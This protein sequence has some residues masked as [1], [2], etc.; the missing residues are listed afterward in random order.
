MAETTIANVKLLVPDTELADAA[1]TQFIDD[2]S[3]V[4]TDNLSGEGYDT[5]TQEMIERYL[6]AHFITVGPE[7]RAASEKAGPVGISYQYK[8]GDALKSTMFGQTAIAL[9]KSGKLAGLGDKAKNATITMLGGD[10]DN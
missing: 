10:G 8:L 1:I 7:P 2:A 9:D 5:T 4:F 3:K 6:T